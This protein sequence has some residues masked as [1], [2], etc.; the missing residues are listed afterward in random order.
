[1]NSTVI[2]SECTI[3]FP[4]QKLSDGGMFTVSTRFSSPDGDAEAEREWQDSI[5]RH[6]NS[7][8]AEWSV[9]YRFERV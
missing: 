9:S 6:L 1:M 7:Y 5:I 4:N 3:T 8:P 2:T